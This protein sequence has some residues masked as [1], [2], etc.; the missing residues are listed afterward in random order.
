MKN[1]INAVLILGAI[2]ASHLFTYCTISATHFQWLSRWNEPVGSNSLQFAIIFI[3]SALLTQLFIPSRRN[4]AV[5]GL[6]LIYLTY[7]VGAKAGL[8]TAFFAYSSYTLGATILGNKR[9]RSVQVEDP[10]LQGL[11]GLTIWLACFYLL[12]LTHY[13]RR[14]IYMVVLAVPVV[15]TI[16][17]ALHTFRANIR[18][19]W[20]SPRDNSVIALLVCFLFFFTARY[21]FFPTVGYDDNALHLKTWTDLLYNHT[22]TVDLYNQIWSASPFTSDLLHGVISVL[23]GYDSRPALNIALL[24]VAIAALYRLAAITSM[25]K[26]S[27]HLMV[28]LFLTT[29]IL[30]ALLGGMQ[31]ELLFLALLGAASTVIAADSLNASRLL[32]FIAILSLLAAT[33]LT[34]VVIVA[35]LFLTLVAHF[36][37]DVWNLLK[38][39]FKN[40][41]TATYLIVLIFFAVF[42]YGFSWIKSGNPLFPLYNGYFKS[43]WFPSIN[44]FDSHYVKG[45]TLK[46]LYG[47]FFN[48]GDYYESANYVAGFQYLF[49]TP[50]SLFC[51]AFLPGA[52]HFKWVLIPAALFGAVMYSSLQY[53]RYLAPILLSCSFMIGGL[54]L[55]FERRAPLALPV[56]WVLA[57]G[58]AIIN[59]LMAPGICWYFSKAPE[60]QMTL[61]DKQSLIEN[62]AP[63]QTLNTFM[64][65]RFPGEG[66]L[67]EPGRPFGATLAARAWYT[68]WYSPEM[69]TAIQNVKTV[70]DLKT[71]V[72]RHPIHFAYTNSNTLWQSVDH[73]RKQRF[74]I[75]YG[76]ILSR[77]VTTYGEVLQQVGGTVLYRLHDHPVSYPAPV[78]NFAGQASA[79][80]PD[81]QA[82]LKHD[83]ALVARKQPK[84]V[85][86]VPVAGQTTFR[87]TLDLLCPA[88]G[89]TYIAQINW[90]D[91]PPYYRQISCDQ[92]LLHFVDA[93]VIPNGTSAGYVYVSQT[94]DVNPV[95]VKALKIELK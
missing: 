70:G 59:L 9:K 54:F 74:V 2:A 71:L 40:P 88:A 7:G 44:F 61:Q 46:N 5:C 93:G 10:L 29:P 24:L 32:A 1:K 87:Y 25:G 60:Q 79:L 65:Q 14:A 50:V 83:G 6:M 81:I 76:S 19:W 94:D 80:L 82:I 57:G 27:S 23:A 4:M 38:S 91:Q 15:Y 48:T 77:Y 22:R 53:Y 56:A 95:F 31:T 72:Q 3:V 39:Q 26:S 84:I 30:I 89:A 78:F 33:K 43:P 28:C 17:A 18:N 20:I 49:L 63:E 8:A 42:P 36:R 11:A 67:F 75:S 73:P 86:V 85:T 64:N 37:L 68:N 51:I 52:R 41:V 55:W 12:S 16:P 35:F 62:I 92:P 66:V 69:G 21:A 13:N 58:F 47:M 45:A 34:G 90:R